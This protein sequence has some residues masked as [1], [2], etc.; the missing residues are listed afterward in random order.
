M[1][2]LIDMGTSAMDFQWTELTM[3]HTQQGY[4]VFSLIFHVKSLENGAYNEMGE[5]IFIRKEGRETMANKNLTY[6]SDERRK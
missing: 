2:E 6:K 3:R 4:Q 1:I 5:L